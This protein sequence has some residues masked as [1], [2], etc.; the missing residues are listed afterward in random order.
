MTERKN[1]V[2]LAK[3][4]GKKP[5]PAKKPAEKKLTPAEERD[6]KAKEKVKQLLQ[7]VPLVPKEKDEVI[8]EIDENPDGEKNVDWLGE[9]VATLTAENES[10]KIEIDVAKV[11]YKKIFDELQRIKSGAAVVADERIFPIFN[12]LQNEYLRYPAEVRNQTQVNVK[13]LLDKFIQIFPETKKLV[14]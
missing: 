6:I 7:D 14:K 9:Q 13:Y 1:I 8:L 11:D 4:G 3:G 5:T 12:E 2:K 10:L